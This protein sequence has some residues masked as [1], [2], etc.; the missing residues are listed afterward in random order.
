MSDRN[1]EIV[2][3]QRFRKAYKASS[4]GLQGLIEGAVYD[5]VK[6]FRSDRPNVLRA[7]GRLAKLSHVVEMDV[8]GARR[9][10]AHLRGNVLHLLDVG[11]KDIVPRYKS[12]L[13]DHDVRQILPVPKVFWP[14]GPESGLRFFTC[15]QRSENVALAG[16]KT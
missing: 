7:Y 10:L 6:R 16:G 14:E 8:A 13:F 15:R 11:G 3:C 2:M 1:P 5:F 12:K 9:L 4:A